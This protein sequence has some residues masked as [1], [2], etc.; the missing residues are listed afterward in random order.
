[1]KSFYIILFFFISIHGRAQ[2][3]PEIEF[4]TYT[5]KDGLSDPYCNKIVQDKNELIWIGT[6]NGISRYDG[7]RF[8]SFTE[9]FKGKDIIKIGNVYNMLP[10][11]NGGMWIGSYDQ[12]FYFNSI[13]ETFFRTNKKGGN[14]Y[15]EKDKVMLKLFDN[16]YLLPKNV[17]K[18]YPFLK[19]LLNRNN[20]CKKYYSFIF[21]KKGELW[22]WGGNYIVKIDKKTR[23]VIKKY[24]FKN[25]AGK[26]FQKLHFDS[27]NRLWVSTWE[28][29]V[30]IFNPKNENL[31]R[32]NTVFNNQFVA[33]GFINWKYQGRNYIVV[34]GD[35]SLLIIDEETLNFKMYE[36]KEGRFRIYDAL[37]DKQGNL[38]LATEFGLKFINSKQNFFHVIP[39]LDTDVTKNKF[40][41]A[42]T[43][44]YE[45]NNIFFIAKRWFDGLYV[46][47]KEWRFKQHIIQFEKHS[48][49]NIDKNFSEILGVSSHGDNNYFS[50]Y[51]G[52]YKLNKNG[53]IKKIIPKGF[54]EFEELY[55]E[56]IV[57]EN[58]QVWWIKYKKGVFK[59]NPIKDEFTENYVFQLNKY[60]EIVIHSIFLT[61]KKKLLVSTSKGIFQLNRNKNNF[62]R[63]NIKDLRNESLYSMCEDKNQ[64]IWAMKSNGFVGINLQTKKIFYSSTPQLNIIY[65]KKICADKYNNIWFHTNEGYWCFIQKEKQIAKYAYKIGLPDNRL[66]WFSMEVKNGKDGFVYAG[67]RNAVIRFDPEKIINFHTKTKV[68][69]S[70]IDANDVRLSTKKINDDT[71]ELVLT[72]GNYLFNMSFSV[73]DY[74]AAKNYELYYNLVSNDEKWIK[75]K[76]GTITISNLSKGNYIIRLKGKNNLTGKNTPLKTIRLTVKPFWWQS[77]WFFTLIFLSSGF[78]VWGITRY[79]WLQRLKSQRYIRNIQESEMKTLRSQMNPHFMFNTLNAINNFIVKNN[80]DSASDY[81]SM[82]SKLMRNILENSKQDFIPLKTELQTLKM[83]LKLEQVRLNNSFDFEITID[84]EI[85]E[86]NFSIP[87]LIIQPYC[88]NAI[89][90]G[91]RNKGTYGLLKVEIKSNKNN[92]FQIVIEDDGIGRVESA[93]LKKNETEHKSYG[94]QIT[95]QRLQLINPQNSVNIIDLYYENG[96]TKGTRIIINLIKID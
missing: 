3:F 64:N 7:I 80:T 89:W 2:S 27:R 12:L 39:I 50:H 94:M 83:Y 49:K 6:R 31:D 62:E 15:S 16:Y 70:D 60:K 47:D 67:A 26:G 4:Q 52:I 92:Q 63:I 11:Q 69:I 96:K 71:E 32:V 87:P 58:K 48:D 51:Y 29:G 45:Y 86:E 75:S 17:T 61:K 59:F 10:I 85:D 84:E 88:E 1:M 43:S 18:D 30:F 40:Q 90:H 13:N 42:V 28:N 55:L 65:G 82:F 21:D 19:P 38:W 20:D 36:D 72:P 77:W 79:V 81:L 8:K 78:I 46:Y 57:P 23:K 9:Y 68:L 25:K 22:S 35:V 93:K 41:K 66:E 33:L 54:K 74:S 37:Q 73:P 44:I 24:N 14:V 56:E 53:K 91:L 34:L 5:D 76:D 95:E